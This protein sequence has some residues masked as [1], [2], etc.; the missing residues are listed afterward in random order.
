MVKP[1]YSAFQLRA[2]GRLWGPLSLHH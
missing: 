2:G 1:G